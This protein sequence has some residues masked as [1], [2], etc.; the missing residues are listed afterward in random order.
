MRRVA[1]GLAALL[2]GGG[3]TY[4]YIDM[5]I[6]S[7]AVVRP[8]YRPF[9]GLRLG[10]AAMVLAQ[11]GLL[12]LPD[13]GKAVFYR[14][15]LGAVAVAVFFTLSGY[16]GAEAVNRFYSA[17]PR[18][19]LL[20]RMLRIVPLYAVALLGTFLVASLAYAFHPLRSLDAPLAGPPWQ[21]R[22]LLGGVMDVVPGLPARRVS[23]QDFAFI[24]FAWTLRTEMLF[25]LAAAGWCAWPK[26]RPARGALLG[27]GYGV[28]VLFLI[29]HGALP[30]QMLCIPFFM[31]G[32]QVFAA[33]PGH[34]ADSVHIGAL[35][36]CAALGFTY[37]H[38]RGHPSLPLQVPLLLVL[39]SLMQVL[40]R[41]AKVPEPLKALDRRCGELSY[42]LY[43][44]HG[45]VFLCLLNVTAYRG[46]PLYAAGIVMSGAFAATLHFCVDAP[47]RNLRTRIRGIGL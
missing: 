6:H 42:P 38:Q 16:V 28:F 9:G 14:L 10:L 5:N 31:L 44:G 12:L 46:W 4:C 23:G 20:N 7:L 45:V 17:R 24:P 19:F 22:I 29:R 30:Q 25:Y 40:A 13:T 26:A 35:F 27:I 11:H 3:P 37:W 32:I 47:L 8:P 43:V 21:W 1:Q 18:Q 39:L 33:R 41:T 36:A 34:L 15:E 2:T